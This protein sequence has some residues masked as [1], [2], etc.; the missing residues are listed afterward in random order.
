MIGNFSDNR[1]PATIQER[2]RSSGPAMTNKP[3][4]PQQAIDQRDRMRRREY[5]AIAVLLAVGLVFWMVESLINYSMVRQGS[6]VKPLVTHLLG[7]HSL[8]ITLLGVLCFVGYALYIS[9]IL[10][11]V[12]AA[13]RELQESEERHRLLTD[14]SLTGIYI[15]QDARL[16]YV[17]ERLAEIIGYSRAE[18]SGKS[19]WDFVHPDDRHLLKET[20]ATRHKERNEGRQ[21][22]FRVMCKDGATKWVQALDVSI[23]YQGRICNMGN[24]ADVTERMLSEKEREK[25]IADLIAAREA[26]HFQATHDHLTGLLNRP[27][28]LHR[29]Q[30]ELERASREKHPVSVIMADLDRFKLIND[31]FGHLAGDAVLTETAHRILSCV[32]PYDLVGRYGGEEIL[33]ALPGSP[34]TGALNCAERI[35]AL[36][37]ES[38]VLTPDGLIEVTLSLGVASVERGRPGDLQDLIRAADKALYAAKQAGRNCVRRPSGPSDEGERSAGEAVV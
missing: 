17:N 24:V 15:V 9:K 28:I 23:P 13:E 16:V 31:N 5:R 33:I 8:L 10:V 22:E 19:F 18:L 14:N 11:D 12:R 27:E 25:L 2:N 37:D 3:K 38:P 26:L 21:Y 34:E 7:Y 35:R 30:V 20:E 29:I 1:G 6:F 32:R 36:V 4:T